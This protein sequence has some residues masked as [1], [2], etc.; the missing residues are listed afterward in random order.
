MKLTNITAEILK[1]CG[2]ADY[3]DLAV[4]SAEL[5]K[6]DMKDLG[7]GLL[8]FLLVE[9]SPSE[10]CDSP[11]EALRRI[12]TARA[13]IQDVLTEIEVSSIPET[14]HRID[15]TPAAEVVLMHYDD[16]SCNDLLELPYR[17]DKLDD[18][19]DGLLTYLLVEM[20]STEGCLSREDAVRRLERSVEDLDSVAAA[21]EALKVESPTP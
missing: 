2:G 21:I 19:G 18:L 16:G 8:T 20:S 4:P 6:Q 7:D 1:V 11:E 13:Q 12:A 14:W 9:L 15:Y 17:R 5:S 10:G 3:A